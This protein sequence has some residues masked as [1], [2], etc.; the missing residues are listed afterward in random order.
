MELVYNKGHIK[1][2]D[3]FRGIAIVLV[4]LFHLYGFDPVRWI[5][6]LGW[7]G[8]DVFFVLSGFLITGILLDNKQRNSYYKVFMIRRILRIVPLYYLVLVLFFII[9]RFVTFPGAGYLLHNQ[10]YFWTYTPNYL[11]AFYGWPKGFEGLNH[12]WSL[13]IEEQFYLFWPF[14]VF[15]L[16]PRQLLFACIFLSLLLFL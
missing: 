1:A 4:L 12:F 14:F 6:I 7:I 15:M 10:L 13:A 16:N 8:V 3:G 5:T 11:F 9:S 2:L